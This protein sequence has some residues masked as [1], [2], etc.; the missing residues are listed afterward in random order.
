MAIDRNMMDVILQSRTYDLAYYHGFADV[1][2]Y[3]TDAL[4][5]ATDVTLSWVQDK[6]TALENAANAYNDYLNKNT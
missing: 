3:V 4:I 1:D 5:G 6:G 2:E